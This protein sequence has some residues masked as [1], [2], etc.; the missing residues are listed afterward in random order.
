MKN[1]QLS[2]T[3]GKL[4]KAELKEFGKFIRSPFFNNRSEVVRFY[5]AVKKYHPLFESG[6]LSNENIFNM[7]YPGKKFSSV[8]N[9]KLISLVLG[10]LME[11]V[12]VKSLR[13]STLE[14]NVKLID[15]LRQK[16]MLSLFEKRS[17]S[18]NE[19]FSTGKRGFGYY[20]SKYKFTTIMNWRRLNKDEKSMMKYLQSELDEF[21]EYFVSVAML[22]YIRLGA[23]E[24]GLN[25]KFDL[26]FYNEVTK[27]LSERDPAEITLATL[28]YNMLMLL[29]T[30]EEKYFFE[31]Q[32][33]RDKFETKL[34]AI[35][36]YNIELVLVQYCYEMVNKGV[37]DY[38]R[39][40]FEI[41]KRILEKNLIPEGFIEPYFFT[42]AVRNAANLKEMKW[43]EQF[44]SEYKK[45]I[46]PETREEIVRYSTAMIEFNKGNFEV[47]LKNLSKINLE[48]S[49]MKLDIKNLLIII[50]YELSYNEELISLIDSYKHYISRD[51]S[52]N[53]EKKQVYNKFINIVSELLKIKLG[54]KGGSSAKLNKAIKEFSYPGY[55][56]WI[57]KKT[58][59]LGISLK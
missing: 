35:D 8:T 6:K 44:V 41:T 50:Y 12:G 21:I 25:L 47:S 32:E 19:L 43:A 45:R 16:E 36:H 5:D 24:R 42:N 15:T 59:E 53:E 17:K 29:N 20:E 14:Y 13:E 51:M 39:H 2:E 52:T 18:L 30:G 55:R 22:M 27:Y 7:V 37:T 54:E 49:N 58:D 23:W 4:N 11:Y 26:K 1:S 28:Y 57:L 34:T 3:L 33:N 46:D 38:R 10:L 9:R 48:K 40:Q 56:E 31:L